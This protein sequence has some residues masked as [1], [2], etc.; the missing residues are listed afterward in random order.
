MKKRRTLALLM[1]AVLMLLAFSACGSSED[2][3]KFD[4]LTQKSSQALD[5]G[6]FVPEPSV[7][8]ASEP[9]P[10]PEA[11]PYVDPEGL[12]GEFTILN[13][14]ND[15]GPGM[16]DKMEALAEEFMKVHPGVTINVEHHSKLGETRTR[17]ERWEAY[18]ARV[19]MELG[20]GEA[21]YLIYEPIE[22]LNLYGLS[23]SGLFLDLW[24]Y[25]ENDPTIDPE[26]YYTPVL[27][28]M[29][30]DG[31]LTVMPFSFSFGGM[32][33][34][35]EIM[36]KLEVDLDALESLDYKTLLDWYDRAQSI[37]PEIHVTFGGVTQKVLY[38][39][40][41]P[42]YLD[43]EAGESYYQSPE[44]IE[45]LT[46]TGALR[47]ADKEGL[48]LLY[49]VAGMAPQD[50][51]W[52]LKTWESGEEPDREF[53]PEHMQV[54]YDEMHPA[55][56]V[57]SDIMAQE[58]GYLGGPLKHLAG[59]YPVV[60]TKGQLG[61]YT[62]ENF[63]LPS[64]MKN[65]DLA[66]KFITFCIKERENMVL[67]GNYYTGRIPINKKNFVHEMDFLRTNGMAYQGSHFSGYDQKS[68]DPQVCAE[69]LDAFLS[70]PLVNKQVYVVDMDEYLKEFYD[71]QLTTPE[72][73]AEKIQGRAYIWLHE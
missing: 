29:S 72:Q 19:L 6:F 47:E 5:E 10:A 63:A 45:F 28:A 25:F 37:D 56:A 61:I 3:R 39:C 21:D 67:G 33:L 34:N 8:S 60:S 41:A 40:E 22:N 24:P 32:M 9:Q 17:Q 54:L 69:K 52:L 59:P 12:T 66:W 11:T 36:E 38:G 64:S 55:I 43:L 48:D 7:P 2:D 13:Y 51:E 18:R 44:F 14:L 73:C 62:N 49:Q 57:S 15:S 46:R 27:E 16:K 53:T 31:K 50:M 65:P 42:A 35:R 4:E 23:K 20:S 70:M 1:A 26:D 30:M 71:N 58:L 68:I